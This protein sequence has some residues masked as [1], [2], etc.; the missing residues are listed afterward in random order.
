MSHYA[1]HKTVTIFYVIKILNVFVLYKFIKF[2][3]LKE[4]GIE[5]ANW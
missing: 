5:L 3:F 4:S 2:N 1:T